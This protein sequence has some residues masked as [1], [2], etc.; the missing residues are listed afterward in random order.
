MR[1]LRFKPLPYKELM[2]RA[3]DMRARAKCAGLGFVW[4]VGLEHCA[5]R[6]PL[7]N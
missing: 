3:F 4:R 6:H 5:T 1:P 2:E 7:N